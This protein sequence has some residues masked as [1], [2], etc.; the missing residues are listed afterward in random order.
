LQTDQAAADMRVAQARAE[1]RRAAAIARQ[2]EMKA[3][4]AER[5]AALVL[6][7]A[8]IPAAMALAFRA[9]RFHTTRSPVR[10]TEPFEGDSR[11][12]SRLVRATLAPAVSQN[13]HRSEDGGPRAAQAVGPLNVQP[14]SRSTTAV[15]L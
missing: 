15:S 14:R 11:P 13:P 8:E 5:Q 2:Q 12:A 7:E 10:R 9:G 3:K 1:V 4:V 6:A